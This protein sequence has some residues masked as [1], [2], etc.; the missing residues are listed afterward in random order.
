MYG[1]TALDVMSIVAHPLPSGGEVSV[2]QGEGDILSRHAKL[3]LDH[4]ATGSGVTRCDCRSALCD[5]GNHH[6]AAPRGGDFPDPYG[7]WASIC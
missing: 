7:G 1:G 5:L 6:P 2:R 3:V 4:T